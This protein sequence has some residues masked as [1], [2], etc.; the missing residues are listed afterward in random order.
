[1]K[2]CW[3]R[4]L[5]RVLITAL[6]AVWMVTV[7]S[8]GAAVTREMPCHGINMPCCPPSGASSARCSGAQCVEQI[9]QKSEASARAPVLHASAWVGL[10]TERSFSAPVRELTTGLRYGPP[11][12]RLK[13]DFRI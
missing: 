13:D 5:S 6:T 8:A 1:M 12:F 9:P 4:S 11:V 2:G 7:V 10:V 3:R